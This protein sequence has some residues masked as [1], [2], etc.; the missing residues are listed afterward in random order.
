M[1]S[2]PTNRSDMVRS[3]R[4][5]EVYL[6]GRPV[7]SSSPTHADNTCTQT[8]ASDTDTR[9]KYKRDL[10]IDSVSEPSRRRG[11]RGVGSD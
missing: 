10:W 2:G 4:S 3:R 11:R 5:T 1:K 8:Y 7:L 6:K 9:I